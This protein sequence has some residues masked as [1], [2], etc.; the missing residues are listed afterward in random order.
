MTVVWMLTEASPRFT[1]RKHLRVIRNNH[2]E[3]PFLDSIVLQK[4]KATK[5]KVFKLGFYLVEYFISF[6]LNSNNSFSVTGLNNTTKFLLFNQKHFFTVKPS[7]S[8]E[9]Y[10]LLIKYYLNFLSF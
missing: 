10:I 5:E 2:N 6:R 8:F 3:P 4:K 9:R 7:F 1:F